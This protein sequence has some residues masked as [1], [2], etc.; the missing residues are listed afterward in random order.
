MRGRRLRRWTLRPRAAST[1]RC[2]R[3]RW[4]CAHTASASSSTG[5]TFN[6]P[7]NPPSAA[8]RRTAPAL[9]KHTALYARR[10]FNSSYP[11]SN[12]A[13]KEAESW[14][15]RFFATAAAFWRSTAR[16][17]PRPAD[18][19][20]P[21]HAAPAGRRVTLTLA[22]HSPACPTRRS[23]LLEQQQE[24]ERTRRRVRRALPSSATRRRTHGR[25]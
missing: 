13:C 18:A 8:A 5:G 24:E 3:S 22:A 23:A 20:P 19:T 11:D 15:E 9:L 21:H 1:I 14:V 10:E 6:P 25:M 12:R 2:R 7:S 4:W 16:R 17:T